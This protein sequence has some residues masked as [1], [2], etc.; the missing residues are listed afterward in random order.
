MKSS[1]SKSGRKLL[2]QSELARHLGLSEW[3][4]SRAINGHPAVKESTR[5]RVLGA[6]RDFGFQPDPFARG[7]RGKGTGLIGVAFNELRN[8]ILLDKLALFEHFLHNNGLRSVLA[9]AGQSVESE[10]QVI[11][12][13]RRLRVDA[14]VLVQSTLS[15]KQS[16]KVLT[17]LKRIHI[18]PMIPQSGSVAV[19]R[20]HGVELLVDHL[21]ELG[22]RKFGTL[23][24]MEINR[25]RWDGLLRGLSKHGLTPKKN[26]KMYFSEEAQGNELFY[27]YAAGIEMA[28]HILA[29]P[30]PPTALIALNDRVAL[31]AA[32]HFEHRGVSVPGRFSVAGFDHLEISECLH[33]KLTTIDHQPQK[34]IDAAGEALMRRLRDNSEPED[35]RE[36]LFIRP[37][38]LPGESTGPTPA[39]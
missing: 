32:Q 26:L 9:L 6:M 27:S 35:F 31:G 15:E 8:S 34:L 4:V 10:M 5:K 11:E 12:D 13:F 22:H 7:L 17:G 30:D 19:D 29:D 21:Y 16:A 28:E 39:H 23:G 18:D 2:S 36:P 20:N 3:T 38:L 1:S 24:I 33:P 14:V 25:W 37:L